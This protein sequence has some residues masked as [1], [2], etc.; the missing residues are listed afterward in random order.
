MTELM[1]LISTVGFPVAASLACGFFILKMEDH[2][3][4]DTKERLDAA[5]EREK[6]LVEQIDKFGDLMCKVNDTIKEMTTKI[7]MIVDN[8]KKL[9]RI[10]E[11]KTKKEV[12]NKKSTS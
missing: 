3:R 1:N 5:N 8:S 9:D 7:E 10:L 2:Y 12:D 11:H 4:Q 6:R